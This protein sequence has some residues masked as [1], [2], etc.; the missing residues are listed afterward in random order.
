[1]EMIGRKNKID[2]TQEFKISRMKEVIKP[3]VPHKHAGYHELIILSG[4]AGVHTI[5]EKD[6]EVNPPTLFYLKKGQVHC[7]DFTQ[8]PKGYVMIFKE[9]FLNDYYDVVRILS[10]LPAL[11]RIGDDRKHIYNDF[12]SIMYEC[13]SALPNQMI[14][15]TYLNVIIYKINDL[16]K[17]QNVNNAENKTIGDYKILVDRYYKTQKEIGFYADKLNVTN[18]KLSLMCSRELGRPASA[19]IIERIVMESKRLLRYTSSTISEIAFDMNFTDPSHFVK[20]FKAKTNLTPLE[21][22]KRF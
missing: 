3:T 22:R 8:I 11:I 14:I 4:G 15:K 17:G 21:V 5:D 13:E 9:T 12:E 20:F 19:I 6:Y 16:L 1:M 2:Q 10:T 18:R 7:W